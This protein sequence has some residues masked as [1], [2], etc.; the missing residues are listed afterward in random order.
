VQRAMRRIVVLLMLLASASLACNLGAVVPTMTP[1]PSPTISG[2]VATSL[3]PATPTLQPTIAPTQ[4]LQSG[5]PTR[6]SVVSTAQGCPANWVSRL[7]INGTG[8]VTPGRPNALRSQPTRNSAVS[9]VVGEIPAGAT[10]VI[11]GGA[12]CAD[13]Y[14][15]WQV[16]FNGAI[17]WTAEGEK[18]TY[19]LEPVS[20]VIPSVPTT[21][22]AC[23]ASLPARL[24]VGLGGMVTPGQPNSLKSAP[25]RTPGSIGQIPANGSFVVVGGPICAD[26]IRWWQVDYNAVIGWTGEGEGSTYWLRP[27]TS[28]TYGDCPNSPPA[29]L[30]NGHYARVT[31][32][33]D[34]VIRNGPAKTGNSVIG[35]IPAGGTFAVT[36]DPQCGD[37]LRWW[38]INY[39]G[40]VGWTAEGEGNTYW[41][42]PIVMPLCANAPPTRLRVGTYGRITPGE[43]N[44]LR[45]A[46]G[47]NASGS[48]VIGNLRQGTVVD[49]VGGPV[50]ADGFLWWQ[51]GS[52][53]QVG[54]TAEGQ[55]ST[56]WMEPYLSG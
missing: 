10:F 47:K 40:I 18:S 20:A 14:A 3:P 27:Y 51:V 6:I 46:P 7:S 23:P 13:G 8:R 19:W 17:G 53:E 1:V 31:P 43:P 26:G 2:T 36:G 34:N 33:L 44:V 21:S 11:L 15:W 42:E 9:R 52:G 32:G 24:V 35:R 12:V 37:V 38:P 29:R 39:N 50:C 30:F 5:N 16:N 55:G 4:G 22:A 25:G 28:G 45:S 54:W 56:Y 48:T 49:I 41:V